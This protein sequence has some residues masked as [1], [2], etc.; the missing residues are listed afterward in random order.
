MTRQL[1]ESSKWGAHLPARLPGHPN[2]TLAPQK[3]TFQNCNDAKMSD[4]GQPQPVSGPSQHMADILAGSQ[5]QQCGAA[6]VE[7]DR[8][9]LDAELR[10]SGPQVT[11]VHTD[12]PGD[13]MARDTQVSLTVRALQRQASMF[14][15]RAAMTNPGN[16]GK[17]AK[18]R[19]VAEALEHQASLISA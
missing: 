7:A 19:A 10:A 2:P 17:S 8:P 12:Q 18:C 16:P 14:L 15:L 5:Q 3:T 6:V 13:V 1:Q 9:V 11:L 4:A